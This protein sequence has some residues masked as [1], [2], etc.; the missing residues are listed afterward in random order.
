VVFDESSH[1]AGA[2]DS[3]LHYY[4]STDDMETDLQDMF[5]QLGDVDLN[6]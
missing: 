6:G 1:K 2:K 5:W 3:T 4:E